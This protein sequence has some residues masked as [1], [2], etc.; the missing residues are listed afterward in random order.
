MTE[1][2]KTQ[3]AQELVNGGCA[4]LALNDY[5]GALR[6]FNKALALCPM[7]LDAYAHRGSA[8]HMLGDTAGAVEDWKRSGDLANLLGM[9]Q[10]A[11]D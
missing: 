3:E 8:K 1:S 7:Y 9:I 6:D 10:T 5:S 11:D 4:K 2:I